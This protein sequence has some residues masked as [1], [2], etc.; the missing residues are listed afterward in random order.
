MYVE[1][2]HYPFPLQLIHNFPLQLVKGKNTQ[3]DKENGQQA[4][5]N[6]SGPLG[7]RL[8][9]NYCLRALNCAVS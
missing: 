7:R 9:E 1:I 6:H 3:K 5:I 4:G 8:F 2:A